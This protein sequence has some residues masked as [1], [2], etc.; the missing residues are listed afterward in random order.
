M[1]TTVFAVLLISST[2]FAAEKKVAKPD[3]KKQKS[4][5]ESV[6]DKTEIEGFL[7]FYQDEKSGS[8]MLVIDES[9]LSKPFIYHTHTVNGVLD[10]GHFK[11]AFRA[12]RLIEF[13]KVFDKIEIV[14]K[15]PRY[16][17]DE[18]SAISRSEG[19]NISEAILASVKIDTQNDKKDRYLIKLD[20]IL[21]T[22]SLEK[23]S[24]YPRP[25]VPG[26][27]AK[28]TF[29]VGK[30][31]KSKTKYIGVRS[32]PKNSDV[33]VEYVFD[34]NAPMVR[35][36]QAVTDPRTVA[37]QI[38]HSFIEL[39]ENN[40]QP[41]RDDPR[42]GYF[43]QQFDDLSS[44][45]WTPFKDVINRWHLVKKDPSSELS[46]PVEPIVWW[47]ENTTPEEWRDI[48]KEAGESW[49]LAF[50]K[51]G[52]KNALQVKVQPDDAEW[53]AGDIRYNVLRWTASPRPPF[54]GYGPSL[55]NPLTGQIIAADIMLEYSY[56]KNRWLHSTLLSEGVSNE[57]FDHLAS[58]LPSHLI[59]SA[60]HQLHDSMMSG[61]VMADFNAMGLDMKHKLVEQAM[62]RLILH[63]IGHTLGLNHNMKASQLFNATDIHDVSKTQG[64]VTASVM[65]YPSANVAPSGV[66]QGDYYDTKPGPYD[67]WVIEYGYSPSLEDS[68]EEEARLQKLLS[69]S[70]EP[71]LAFGNDA[72]DMRSPGRHIDPRVMIGDMSNESVAYAKG[73]LEL[74][75]DTFA[76]L[77]S[78]AI[79]EGA[80]YQRLLT[81]TNFLMREWGLQSSVVSRYIG[82][83]Y[84][85]RAYAGQKGATQ[86]FRAVEL[87]KQKEA[88]SVL[89]DYL[90]APN[91]MEQAEPIFAYLQ[92]QRR[93]FSG[94][95]KNE[96][97]K[98]H[99]MVLNTQRK[100]F[101]HLLHPNVLKRI[102]DSALYG[103]KYDLN[104]FLS[105]LTQGVFEK[106]L[107][108]N[109]NTFRQN[110]QVEYVK[111][112]I[113][114]V[115]EKSPYD[116]LSKASAM[117]QLSSLE[118]TMKYNR[119]KGATRV[120]REY[121]HNFIEK[122]LLVEKRH[123]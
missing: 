107:N 97:P 29:N 112:L 42:V 95:G 98:I 93:G 27:P 30:L 14:S 110:L 73:R 34:N 77:K 19:T 66:T 40:Y 82:G 2:S 113:K 26:Q 71:A 65:D 104:Q 8:L 11:G 115:D 15:T 89:N 6:K 44:S 20:P 116:Y 47:I 103:N 84:T 94:Y 76:S 7:D 37:I 57:Q 68:N 12:N 51:A 111:R 35:G 61:M 88:L 80:N 74:I 118:K 41:R 52:F 56:F 13:R 99:D 75:N 54:G 83:V 101:D 90:F 67:L 64:N 39:P 36:S 1:A 106:D 70:T 58:D 114:I 28:P 38:Q 92:P 79:E 4:I 33:V 53:D 21:L 16:I 102:S 60:G 87:T 3:S 105:D 100:V 63:E 117:A 62:R 86:P 109:V 49:N 23:V 5:T 72:E 91:I 108:G 119:G 22:E 55:P 32:Y 10:A 122:V 81:A 120:H 85:D 31:S 45:S 78:K 43:T 123:I 24:P 17:L 48:I 59:C 25:P 9:Q 18:E 69:R 96:D 46:E 50:E 121:L